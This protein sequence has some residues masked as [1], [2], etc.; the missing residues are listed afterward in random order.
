M[1]RYNILSLDGGGIRGVLTIRLI[2]HLEEQFPGFLEQVDLITGTSTGG[3]LTL[4]LAA[5]LSPQQVREMYQ[6]MGQKVFAESPLEVR[7]V[8]ALINLVKADYSNVPLYNTLKEVLG[9][10]TLGQLKKKVVISSFDLDNEIVKPERPR[11]WKAKFFHNYDSP[12]TDS[13]QKVVDVALRTSAAPTYFPIFQGYVDGGVVANNPSMCALAQA[14]EGTT[15]KQK[16][17]DIALLSIGTGNNPTFLTELNDNWGLAKWAVHLIP[18]M[19]D[20]SVG[21]ADYQCKQLLGSR[22]LR[23]NPVLHRNIPMDAV[24]EIPYLLEV[25][26]LEKLDD[27][28]AWLKKNFKRPKNVVP[29][30][31]G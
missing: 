23:L 19:M 15:G 24:K 8:S 7:G 17:R 20:G 26:D 2:E 9:D 11:T 30:S 31:N 21:L 10:I 5:G 14:V 27:V 13:A 25:A 22:Y 4:A 18:L 3:I 1:A 16:L 12:G 6:T 29:V 28:V